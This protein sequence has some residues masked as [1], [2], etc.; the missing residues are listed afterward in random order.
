MDEVIQCMLSQDLDALKRWPPATF[1]QRRYDT[2]KTLLHIACTHG[3]LE[4]AK[5]MVSQG[6]AVATRTILNRSPLFDACARGHLEVAQWLHPLDPEVNLVDCASGYTP[7]LAACRG[8]YFDCA[9]W[10]V[11]VGADRTQ[12]TFNGHSALTLACTYNQSVDID[13]FDTAADA[14]EINQ[15]THESILHLAC[16]VENFAVLKWAL[17]KGVPVT[18]NIM[19]ETPL[20]KAATSR[21]LAFVQALVPYGGVDEPDFQDHTPFYQACCN[22]D[23]DTAKCLL[24]AGANVNHANSKGWTAVH[25]VCK[26]C[27]L[28]MLKWLISCRAD[29]NVFDHRG[30]TPIFTAIMYGDTDMV[31]ILASNGANLKARDHQ[32][33]SP[34]MVA[35]Q[36]HFNQWM[37]VPHHR[38]DLAVLLLIHGCCSMH[39]AED[40]IGQVGH[41]D[42][43]AIISRLERVVQEHETLLYSLL[44]VGKSMASVLLQH[45]GSF[46]LVKVGHVRNAR[47]VL[48][49]LKGK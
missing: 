7:F 5:Y 40:A 1:D 6:G 18:R 35:M 33:E 27:D 47:Q 31:A 13:L 36:Y 3:K 25:E 4:A 21:L 11:S 24:S 44:R 34:L 42:A 30:R 10:L 14:F 41:R 9:K 48:V 16:R 32:G 12:R 37:V 28:K 19:L 15:F 23:L 22:S 45:V 46:L 43:P 29:V 2:D 20:Y 39:H 8:G 26:H 49:F 17:A 38:F